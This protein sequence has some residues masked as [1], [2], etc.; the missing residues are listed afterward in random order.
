MYMLLMC[1]ILHLCVPYAATGKKPPKKKASTSKPSN[2]RASP[3]PAS[4]VDVKEASPEIDIDELET[5]ENEIDPEPEQ[6]VEPEPKRSKPTTVETIEVVEDVDV[7]GDDDEVIEVLEEHSD[8]EIEDVD[9][10]VLNNEFYYYKGR[11]AIKCMT[12]D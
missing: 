2:K 10:S 3:A 4:P 9:V 5:F 7:V 8:Y 6:E 12:K 1:Q 11:T